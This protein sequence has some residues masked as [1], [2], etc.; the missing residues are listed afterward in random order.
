MALRVAGLIAGGKP[1]LRLLE[2]AVETLAHHHRGSS[3]PARS[4][5]LGAPLRR[6]NRRAAA[7]D[8]LREAMD[9]AH[10]RAGF[11]LAERRAGSSSSVA[12]RALSSDST[13]ERCSD[14]HCRVALVE[15]GHH[16]CGAG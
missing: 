13:G 11:T 5:Y 7:R 6:A 9:I 16:R 3:T 8:P 10:R 14:V 1:G 15:R 12:P 2:Q 4:S